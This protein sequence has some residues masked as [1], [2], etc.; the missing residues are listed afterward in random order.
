MTGSQSGLYDA[1]IIGGGPVG[2]QA[3][4][5]L[6]LSG[7]KV[8]VLEKRTQPYGPVCC[9]GIVSRECADTFNFNS[10]LTLRRVNSARIFLPVR[11][12]PQ[13]LAPGN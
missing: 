5:Q 10:N 6:S 4:Y 2:C 1:A 3:A 8:V 7:H 13:S 12:S 11:K 9:T